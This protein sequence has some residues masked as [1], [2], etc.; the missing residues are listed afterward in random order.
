MSTIEFSPSRF[1]ADIETSADILG[2]DYCAPM[3]RRVLDVFEESFHRGAVLWRTTDR[4][5]GAL[6][7]R[8]YERR[9][10]DTV[11]IAERAGFIPARSPAAGLIRAWS[12][13]YAGSRELC[14]FDSAQGLVKTWVYLDGRRPVEEV[15]D[16]RGIPDPIRRH[17]SRFREL[18]LT[19]VRNVAVD[20]QQGTANLYFRTGEGIDAGST[21]RLLALSGGTM[22]DARTFGDM[23]AFTAPGGYT[24]S[25]TLRIDTGRIERVGFYALRLPAG[26]FPHIGGR[27]ATFFDRVPS[28]DDAEMNAVAWSF[29]SGNRRYM[30]A[31]RSYCG[32][33]VAL[34]HDCDSPMT[35]P[36][37]HS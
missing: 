1:L 6:N 33:L 15:L 37:M 31:E 18:G 17:E 5:G 10:L 20:Y 14:D 21:K 19:V 16:T 2:A 9:P 32:R 27:L 11:C 8:F 26:R 7:Y 29:G 4:P 24:F 23:L 12:G 25:V 13:L 34:M 30:K 35:V 36:V 22:P 3:T 28:H